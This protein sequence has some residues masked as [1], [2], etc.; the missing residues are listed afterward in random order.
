MFG[1]GL[2]FSTISGLISF[3]LDKVG[4]R[5]LVRKQIYPGK[6]SSKIYW[7]EWFLFVATW[8]TLSTLCC[9]ALNYITEFYSIVIAFV[10]FLSS[11]LCAAI[12]SAISV[13]LFPTNIRAMAT[14]FI[15]MFGRFVFSRNLRSIYEM[16]QILN[17]N[18]CRVGGL[19]GGN[20][21]GLLVEN[22]CSMIFYVFAVLSISKC[23]HDWRKK[24]PLY[25][26][27][28]FVS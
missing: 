27:Y 20:L 12:I 25:Q 28:I 16:K 6:S 4:P 26:Y 11:S 17:L 5:I 8:L 21:V 24:A 3:Y 2:V 22:N 18:L 15:Y 1:I 23:I 19:V 9:A 7:F 14:C 13:S 10:A